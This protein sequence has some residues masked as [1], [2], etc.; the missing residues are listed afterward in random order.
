MN[1]FIYE[2]ITDLIIA[3]LEQ[4]SVPWHK[5]WSDAGAPKSLI[6]KRPYKGINVFLLGSLNYEQPYFLSFNQLKNIGGSVRKDEKANL[7]VFYK[8]F[9]AVDEKGNVILDDRGNA[10]KV[11]ML[12]YYYVFNIAQCYGIDG[13]Y[14]PEISR[15]KFNPIRKAE[16]IFEDMPTK[17]YMEHNGP[18]ACY[19]PSIDTIKLPPTDSFESDEAIYATLFH[20]MVHATGHKSRLNRKGVAERVSLGSEQYSQEELIAEM[21]A[22]FLCAEAGIENKVINNSAAYIG[23]WL[24]RLRDDKKMVILAA[25]AAQRACDY[26]LGVKEDAE[27][28]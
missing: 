22:A 3:K 1:A 27:N 4:G 5:P 10:K 26:I 8:W 2:K 24:S 20:E 15:R 17:P 25:G 19:Y 11:P 13:K 6:T 9:E 18:D 12:R 16:K 14:I 7:V 28:E 23:S 21:G